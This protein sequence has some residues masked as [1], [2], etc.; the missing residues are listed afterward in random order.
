M[1]AL[2]I[3]PPSGE[4]FVK[5]LEGGT[6]VIGRSEQADLVIPDRSLSRQHARLTFQDGIWTIEDL[7]SRN[8][9]LVNRQRIDRPTP[10]RPGDVVAL[11]ASTFTV[12]A[13]GEAAPAAGGAG[14]GFGDHT[15]FRSAAALLE[16]S[17]ALQPPAG[18][19]ADDR[20]RSYAERLRTLNEV[21]EALGRTV[22]IEDLLDL[23]L[24]RAF[25]ALR[26]EEGAIFLKSA[27]GEYD[28][29]A[30]KSNRGT[31]L[32][33]LY[34]T[35]LIREVAEKGLAALVL[36]AEV[37]DRFN[38]AMSILSAGVRSLVA[39]P[40]LDPDGPLGMIVL[41]STLSVRRF[42]EEDMQLLVSLASVAAMRIRNLRLT[43]EAAERKRL[44]R[45]VTLA[46]EIQMALLPDRLPEVPGWELH[47]GNSPSRGVSGD[48][49]KV[50]ERTP[51]RDYALFVA[52]VSG[53]GI[54]AA[55]LTASLEALVA[56]QIELATPPEQACKLVSRLLYER[57]SPEKYATGFLGVLDAGAGTL[58]Y[59][60]AGHNPG[61]LVHG[62]GTTEWLHATGAPLGLM[63]A[64]GYGAAEITL[65]A[66]D[67]VV[68]YTD[69]I[70]EANNPED[71]EF[72]EQRLEAAC[73]ANRHLPPRE[74]AAA[75][76]RELETFA[77]GVPYADDRTMVILRKLE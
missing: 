8:G 62:D 60:S 72:G 11:G 41:E 27:D 73:V 13:G 66:G 6:H 50:V 54:G 20:F 34:S 39:A 35:N 31:E 1:I 29:V 2:H 76:D 5:R 46:R 3:E 10:L 42:N 36:D 59:A 33:S 74:L 16:E 49:F 56:A 65:A 55:L 40:L 22:A 52:D 71:E 7:G 37:D 70:T 4:A 26:P 61:L 43:E 69:G 15:M 38:Q 19:P 24:D 21:H 57:T 12:R 68:L 32:R 14:R 58:R 53:K 47:G 30:S 18:A 45:E 28:C 9:T 63:P 51:G 44:E 23:I 77:Q 64:G 75:L 25:A 17:G 67:T 48:L